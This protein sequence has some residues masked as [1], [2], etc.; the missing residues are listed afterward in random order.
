MVA[1]I[2]FEMLEYLSMSIIGHLDIVRVIE[3]RGYRHLASFYSS[4]SRNL[5]PRQKET[6][7]LLALSMIFNVLKYSRHTSPLEMVEG[8]SYTE[9]LYL[10]DDDN[11]RVSR[12]VKVMRSSSMY[13]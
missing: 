3:R 6:H 1:I 2:C 11:P 4:L 10:I 8:I 9:F 13:L 5:L 12:M 7:V